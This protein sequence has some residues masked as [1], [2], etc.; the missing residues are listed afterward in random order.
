MP[1]LIYF[2]KESEGP[3]LEYF[4]ICKKHVE[5][6]KADVIKRMDMLS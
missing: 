6:M 3:Q 5:I 1:I 2:N 4:I